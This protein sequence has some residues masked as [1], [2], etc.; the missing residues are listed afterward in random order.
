M[1][2]RSV[3]GRNGKYQLDVDR[4]EAIKAAV[5]YGYPTTAGS[6]SEAR[7]EW[8]RCEAAIDKGIRNLLMYR[9]DYQKKKTVNQLLSETPITVAP[10]VEI[11]PIDAEPDEHQQSTSSLTVS[12]VKSESDD[13]E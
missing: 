7:Y 5:L 12:E 9:R 3:H 2:G 6:T 10:T 8:N 1:E 11:K 4:M 13:K